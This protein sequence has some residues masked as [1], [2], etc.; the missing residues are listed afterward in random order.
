MRLRDKSAIVTGGGSGIG[1][2]IAL[3]FAREGANVAIADVSINKAE[4]VKQEIVDLQRRTLAIY[5]DVSKEEDAKHLARRTVEELGAIDILVNSAG[6]AI[7][8]PVVDMKVEDWDSTMAVNLRG[9]FLCAQAV[10]PYMMKQRSGKII[11][12]SSD[13]GKKGWAT[14]SAYCASKFGVLGLTEALSKEVADEYGINVNA[15]CPGLVDTQMAR[16][17]I[18][19]AGT[20]LDWTKVIQPNDIANVAVFLA[21]DESSAMFGASIDVFGLPIFF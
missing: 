14:G 17:A 18:A 2:A 7:R 5:C 9:P 6:I 11:N 10:L 12:I 13:S 19:E 16:S 8:S 4:K 1:R 21:S 15:I 20:E 3:A